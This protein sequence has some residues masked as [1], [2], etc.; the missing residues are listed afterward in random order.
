MI[1]PNRLARRKMFKEVDDLLLEG[2]F[3]IVNEMLVTYQNVNNS[4]EVL[5]GLARI[6]YAAKHLL[7][8]YN[9][10]ILYLQNHS[11][12]NDDMLTGLSDK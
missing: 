1:D 5:V 12:I 6:S 3:D 10:Y 11:D 2:K 9:S 7:P 4:P 8:N